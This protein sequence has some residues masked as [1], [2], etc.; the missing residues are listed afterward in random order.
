MATQ[1]IAKVMLALV[2]KDGYVIT[3]KNGI[4]GVESDNTGIFTVEGNTSE[5]DFG[6]ASLALSGLAG[7]NADIYGSNKLVYVSTGKAK[8][9]SVLTVNAMPHAVKSRILG[10]VNG[11]IG[12]INNA[13]VAYLAESAEAFDFDSPV[14][15]GMYKG[16]ASEASR[17][18][19][20]NNQAEVRNNDAITIAHMER[21]D[22]GFG[23]DVHSD[24]EGFNL[25]D[26]KKKVFPVRP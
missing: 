10:Q 2:D 26:L 17:T 15:T 8:P 16:I 9:Q 25:D 3:G 6:V 7:S 23:I 11:K 1:G 24:E 22:D 13:K 14:Y 18:M 4:N 21:G 12:S 19:G 20:T 5:N